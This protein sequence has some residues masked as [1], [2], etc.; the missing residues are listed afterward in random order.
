M[1]TVS[2]GTTSKRINSI[3]HIFSGGG[4]M[5]CKLKEPCSMQTPVFVVQGLGKGTFYNY[6]SFEG[7]YY[8]VDDIVYLTNN[9]Q[10]VHCHLD[11]LATYAD[12][13]KDTNAFVVYGDAGH[14]NEYM[15]DFRFQ[16]EEQEANSVT[17]HFKMFPDI[18]DTPSSS[19]WGTIIVKT[20][21]C[22]DTH[23]GVMTYAMTMSGFMNMLLDL[24][25]LIAGTSMTW[26]GDVAKDLAMVLGKIGGLGSWRDNLLSATFV[27][28]KQSQIP[29]TANSEIVLGGIKTGHYATLVAPNY[30]M[31]GN[32]SLSIPWSTSAQT[33]KFLRNTRWCSCQLQSLSGYSDVDVT[34]IRE[35]TGSCGMNCAVD[36]CTGE[37][38]L[39][40][41][42][43]NIGTGLV[44]GSWSGCVGVDVTGAIGTGATTGFTAFMHKT[45]DAIAK[46]YTMGGSSMLGSVGSAVGNAGLN[47]GSEGMLN[48]GVGMM[49]AG[50]QAKPFGNMIASGISGA[51]AP[52]GVTA[53][54]G[55][56]STGGGLTSL[57]LG[58]S[59][60]LFECVLRMQQLIPKDLN[61]YTAYC[62]RYGYPCNQY[63]QIG[64]VSGYVQCAGATVSGATGASEASKA[65]IN[66]YLNSGL[67]IE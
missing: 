2:I 16:P 64:S 53:G 37:W 35:Q 1:P 10:E 8:W 66:S 33:Y 11:P 60:Y 19:G 61:N 21:A 23:Y 7:R 14:W 59:S 3:S 30:V 58:G 17:T 65:T 63:L 25:S 43:S 9:I 46:V 6:A 28:F 34:Y 22:T 20:M 36:L 49:K 45:V 62:D 41:R 47:A 57:F 52:S 15:D 13:I 67:Y 54:T 27:P 31:Y 26:V 51:L 4:S 55:S 44:L 32:D 38:S 5:S 29:G 40:L 24:S 12:A 42:E 39:V 50:E 18:W 56:G 48:A